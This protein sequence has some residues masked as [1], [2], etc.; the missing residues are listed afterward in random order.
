MKVLHGVCVD[1]RR[2][3]VLNTLELLD[4]RA[5]RSMKEFTKATVHESYLM[6]WVHEE[7]CAELDKFLAEVVAKKSPRLMILAPPRHGK[8]L[9]VDELIPTPT[10]F[11]RMGDL[12][13]GDSVFAIDGSITKIVAVSDTWRDREAYRVTTNTGDSIIADAAHEWV[14]R[15]DRGHKTT[16]VQKSGR[17]DPPSA[18]SWSTKETRWLAART[19]SRR[20]LIECAGALQLP[21]ADLPI[22][23]YTLGVWLGDGKNDCTFITQGLEDA[24]F[25]LNRISS[26]SY[27]TRPHILGLLPKLRDAGLLGNKHIPKMYLRA[28]IEQRMAL[29]QGLID[30]DGHVSPDGQIEFCNTNEQLALNTAELIRSLGVKVSVIRGRSMLYGKDCGPKFRVMFYMKNAASL[31]RKAERCKNGTKQPGHYLSFERVEN[32]DTVCIE[33]EHPS[34]LFLAGTGFLPTRNTELASRRLPAFALGK[35]PD[36]S[37]IATSYAADLASSNNRDVQRVMESDTYRNLFPGSRLNDDN[38]RAVTDGSFLRNS[39]IFEVVGCRGVYKSSGVGGG[40]TGRGMDLGIIDDPVKDAEQAYSQTYRDKVWEWYQSTFYTRLMPGG[41]ILVILTRWHEDDLAGRLLK[42][43]KN[44]GEQWQVIS[45]PAI[46]EVDDVHRKIGEALH[47]ERYNI[48]QLE[49][50]QRAVGTR[51]WASLFQQRPAAREGEIFKRAD[52]KFFKLDP[53][54]HNLQAAERRDYLHTIG[55]TKLVQ[56]WDTAIGEKKKNDFAACA[57]LGIS[58]IGY[59]LFDMW[60]ARIKYPE[61]RRAVQ[62]QYDKWR[63][64]RVV[65]EGGGSASGKAVVQDLGGSTR[66]PLKEVSTSKDKTFRAD[67]LSPAHE[68]GLC[69]LPEGAAWVA[70]FLDHATG[71][72]NIE[73][74]DD[75]DAWMLSMEDAISRPKRMQIS[76]ELL[77]RMA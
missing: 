58:P 73:N 33:I 49:R 27:T 13:V 36:L 23:P 67:L 47:P 62:V 60:Q 76:D 7:I 63:P 69:Y 6:G 24:V 11:A 77:R 59:Y 18:P 29:L 34:H 56:A 61:M 53:N 15:L 26:E 46:A 10:G 71:F 1:N 2:I 14:V 52:W 65:V 41:G 22:A 42:D 28:S 30:S 16:R 20:P 45:Y 32:T 39:D 21:D 12:R 64:D 50:I 48:E 70:N 43:A 44:G 72:P 35:Y 38:I 68:A 37:I 25:V 66:I 5:R 55:V 31:P 8:A 74:D 54:F 57:T 9:S 3:G 19:G 40:I 17:I 4:E 51:V 75:V